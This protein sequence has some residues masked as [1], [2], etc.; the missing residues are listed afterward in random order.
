M[1]SSKMRK[2]AK[3]KSRTMGGEKKEEIETRTSMEGNDRTKTSHAIR[4]NRNFES[5]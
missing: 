1:D 3:H 2:E 5:Q 4:N